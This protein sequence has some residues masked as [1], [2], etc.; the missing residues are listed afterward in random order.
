M[1]R[2]THEEFQARVTELTRLS[3]GHLFCASHEGQQ[4]LDYRI[5]QNGVVWL[6]EEVR[7]DGTSLYWRR[8]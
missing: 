2:V 8:G 6:R 4:W 3:R 5:V 7:P 1:R